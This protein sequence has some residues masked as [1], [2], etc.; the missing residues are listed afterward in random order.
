[1]DSNIDNLYYAIASEPKPEVPLTF[2]FKRVSLYAESFG[3]AMKQL[4]LQYGEAKVHGL[5][6]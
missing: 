4:E 1:M 6:N 2:N 5:Y 3:D